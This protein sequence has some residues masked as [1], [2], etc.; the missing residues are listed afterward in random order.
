MKFK[1]YL[2]KTEHDLEVRARDGGYDVDIDGAS[3]FVDSSRL[4]A[5]FYSLIVD[6]RSYEVSVEESDRDTYSVRH[7]GYLRSIRLIDPLS[8]A[9]GAG[10]GVSGPSELK[11]FMPGRVVTILVSEGDAVEEGQPLLVLEAMKMENQVEAP[12]DG[13][14]KSISVSAGDTVE[15]GAHLAIIE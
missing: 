8:A 15:A 14:V 2:G 11:A 5:S 9:A 1:A 7:G 10:L 6:G 13:V 12:R 4:E 3:T